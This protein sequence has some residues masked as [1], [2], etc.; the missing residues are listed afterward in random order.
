MPMQVSVVFLLTVAGY[1]SLYS[2][3]EYDDTYRFIRSVSEGIF[4]W[5]ASHI[6]MQP[7]TVVWHMII[8]SDDAVFSQR[9]INTV[10]AAIS[11]SIFYVLLYR[12]GVDATRRALLVIIAAVS[13]SML[14]LG[15]SGSMHLTTAPWLTAALYQSVMWER[16]ALTPNCQLG[17]LKGRV[18]AAAVYL[19]IG[20]V[21]LLNTVVI[22]PFLALSMLI[23]MRNRQADWPSVASTALLFSVV[24]LAIALPVMV[25]A[26]QL[27][28]DGG[29]PSSFLDFLLAKQD[30]WEK[31][32]TSLPVAAGQTVLH[33]GKNFVWLQDFSAILRAWLGGHVALDSSYLKLLAPEAAYLTVT[34]MVL[35]TV[36]I[37][38][39]IRFRKFEAPLLAP[40]AYLLGCVVFAFWWN[41]HEAAFYFPATLP[42]A[43]LLALLQP[44]MLSRSLIAV[45]TLLLVPVNLIDRAY[46]KATYPASAFENQILSEFDDGDL[47]VCFHD[48]PGHED[49]TQLD[50]PGIRQWPIDDKFR[51][52]GNIEDLLA[53]T[54]SEID[55]VLASGGRVIVFRVLDEYDWHAPWSWLPAKGVEKATLHSFFHRNYAIMPARSIARMKT[56]ELEELAGD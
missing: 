20:T 46:T 56:W 8:G 47:F 55:S 25:A 4:E 3:L 16:A 29:P 44:V 28:M 2:P 50:I 6:L 35:G 19:A 11:F 30:S 54:Q 40:T 26:H 12:L 53:Q 38:T 39:A 49:L 51:E 9:S 14:I 36:F 23:V 18:V 32:H 21:F 15:T 48:W 42:T 1:I 24:Y 52:F 41:Y 5:D 22:L 17:Q 27:S 43:V 34:L 10:S 37:S 13:T 45:L 31:P 7:V 33:V